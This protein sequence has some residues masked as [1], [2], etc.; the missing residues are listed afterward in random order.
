VFHCW[1][2]FHH[3]NVGIIHH[4]L[5]QAPYLFTCHGFPVSFD[6]Y[7]PCALKRDLRII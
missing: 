1:P 4:R 7:N 3:K 5:L 2:Q 6:V